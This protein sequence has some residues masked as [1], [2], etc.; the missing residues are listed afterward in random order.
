MGPSALPPMNENDSKARLV[1]SPMRAK[2]A[3]LPLMWDHCLQPRPEASAREVFGQDPSD[4]KSNRLHVD[5]FRFCFIHLRYM[6]L[7]I[8]L[9]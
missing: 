9:K 8:P 4:Y 6:I 2:L 3:T 1:K 5:I 7:S